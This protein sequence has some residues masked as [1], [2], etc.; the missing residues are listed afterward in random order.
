MTWRPKRRRNSAPASRAR[1][2]ARWKMVFQSGAEDGIHTP[3]VELYLT[4]LAPRPEG[5]GAPRSALTV[6]IRLHRLSVLGA[7][8]GLAVG[9]SHH[10]G[11]NLQ[12]VA[13]RIEEVE[14]ATAA[15]AQVTAPLKA[16]DQRPI[17][18]LDALGMQMCQGLEESIT[19]LDLKGDLLD[20][21]LAR[22]GG[23][24]VYTRR[25]RGDHEVVV[26]VVKPQEG[27]LRTIGTL[28]AIGD[29]T[30]QHFSVETERTLEVRDQ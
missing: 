2:M 1:V 30:P 7:G 23:S 27:A 11:K 19:V 26:H 17:D 20:Q 15:A 13:I 4:P 28:V 18:D 24:H 14:R 25:G 29:L 10:I 8:K 5:E 12:T 16:V 9:H 22:A 21:P 3:T 6:H